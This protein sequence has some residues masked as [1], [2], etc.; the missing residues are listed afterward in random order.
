MHEVPPFVI[1]YHKY[2]G[3]GFQLGWLAKLIDSSNGYDHWWFQEGDPVL[4]NRQRRPVTRK[5]ILKIVV[6]EHFNII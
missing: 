5:S 4:A 3:Y 2:Y 6:L 1:S